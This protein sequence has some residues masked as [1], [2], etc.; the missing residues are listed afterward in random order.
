MMNAKERECALSFLNYVAREFMVV[1]REYAVDAAAIKNRI[2]KH[3]AEINK[4]RAMPLTHRQQ[5]V[6]S[7][8]LRDQQ[9]FKTWL[10]TWEI[11]ERQ[12]Y[13]ALKSM[14]VETK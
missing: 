14:T 2:A 13:Q 4:F 9:Y 11:D 8:F 12:F 5:A 6:L 10:K 7:G 3:K 1:C